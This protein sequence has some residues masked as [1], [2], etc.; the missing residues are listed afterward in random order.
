MSIVDSDAD[1]GYHTTVLGGRSAPRSRLSW[2]TPI[3][4]AV[5]SAGGAG[6]VALA[7][8]LADALAV[9]GTSGVFVGRAT[10]QSQ[11]QQHT[12]DDSAK[13]HAAHLWSENAS[14]A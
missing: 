2:R 11:D 1:A 8:A 3:A 10:G 9:T 12:R 6:V 5:F 4:D 7:R 13:R 14:A